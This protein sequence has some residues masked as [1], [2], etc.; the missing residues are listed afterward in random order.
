MGLKVHSTAAKDPSSYT[1]AKFVCF[2][3]FFYSWRLQYSLKL[4][5]SAVHFYSSFSA[6]RFYISFSDDPF[7]SGRS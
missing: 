7:S 5:F 2:P 4:S 6:V 3:F 1:F